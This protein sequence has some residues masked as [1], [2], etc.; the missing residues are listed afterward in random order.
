[1]T[2]ADLVPGSSSSHEA[3]TSGVRHQAC[4][5]SCCCYFPNFKYFIFELSFI[6][7]V[8]Q[9]HMCVRCTLNKFALLYYSHFLT[10]SS[11]FEMVFSVFHFSLSLCL[12]LCLSLCTHSHTH[13]P[14]PTHVHPLDPSFLPCPTDSPSLHY[15]Q[16][17]LYIHVPR[18]S[19]SSDDL[20]PTNE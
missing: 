5:V 4:H 7:N 2:G 13:K 8:R 11:L 10:F 19:S 1:L 16:S 3:A 6:N 12:C 15:G 18:P 20:G 9:F 14:I 17:P